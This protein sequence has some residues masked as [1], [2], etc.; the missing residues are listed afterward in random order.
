MYTLKYRISY[1]STSQINR[2][3]SGFHS[4]VFTCT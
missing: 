3:K 2:I 4:C 1:H